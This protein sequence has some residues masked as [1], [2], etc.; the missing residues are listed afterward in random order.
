MTYPNPQ[1]PIGSDSLP[2]HPGPLV[3]D[4][5]SP[6][7]QQPPQQPPKKRRLLLIVVGVVA[8]LFVASLV[9]AAG[10]LSTPS[11]VATAASEPGDAPTFTAS[12]P[13]DAPTW[14]EEAPQPPTATY[15]PRKADWRLEIKIKDQ[16]CYDYD[17]SCDMTAKISADFEGHLSELPAEGTIE[18]SYKLTGDTSGPILGTLTIDVVNETSSVDEHWL[19]TSSR[20]VKPKATVTD[21]EYSE[22]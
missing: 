12:E 20:G 13:G 19:S 14:A 1:E 7:Q 15:T 11:G 21:I 9:F 17:D 5:G 6:A 3:P 8:L 16:Q 22:W 4:Y 10:R 18:I 2:Q